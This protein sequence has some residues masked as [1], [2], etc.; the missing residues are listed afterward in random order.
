MYAT[1]PEK[2]TIKN[3]GLAY[4]KPNDGY[5]SSRGG[6]TRTLLPNINNKNQTTPKLPPVTA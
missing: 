3:N 1:S 2:A 6:S 4:I 5:E